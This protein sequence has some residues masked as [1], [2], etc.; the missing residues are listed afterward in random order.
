MKDRI[1]YNG[2]KVYIGIDVHRKTYAVCC[3]CEGQVVKKVTF[4]A[5]ARKLS[6][7]LAKNFEGAELE[8]AYDWY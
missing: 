8:S 6:E 5:E 4:P 7:W 3:R 2:K 1:D